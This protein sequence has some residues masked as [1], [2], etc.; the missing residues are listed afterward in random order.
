MTRR[1]ERPD[2]DD[3]NARRAA[4]LRANLQKRKAQAR[5]RADETDNDE[6]P[7]GIEH[8]D[9]ADESEG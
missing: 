6:P 1:P 3:R 8:P 7:P 5:S 2:A 4:A 9:R